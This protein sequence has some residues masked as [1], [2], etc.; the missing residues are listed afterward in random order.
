VETFRAF[1]HTGI[2]RHTR[3][4]LP[5]FSL[6]GPFFSW[7]YLYTISVDSKIGCALSFKKGEL[8][9]I[10]IVKNLNLQW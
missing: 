9:K 5:D 6:G 7:I 2:F 8:L 3:P 10:K 1:F 4:S